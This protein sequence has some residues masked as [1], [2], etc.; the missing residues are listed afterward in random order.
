MANLKPLA[1]IEL[2]DLID[3][4]RQSIVDEI[5]SRM[6]NDPKWS[7][8]TNG[9][10]LHH[11]STNAFL[12]IASY[13]AEKITSSQNRIT[14]DL[15]L[16][17]AIDK[18]AI[19]DL[20]FD[21]KIRPRQNKHAEVKVRGVVQDVI[22]DKTFYL[23][24]FTPLTATNLNGNATTY[25]IIKYDYEEG[26]FNYFDD[27]KIDPSVYVRDFFD[28][29]AYSGSTFS[30]QFEITNVFE[31]FILELENITDIIENS[32]RVYYH[33]KNDYI[34]L[35]ET[36]TFVVAPKPENKYFPNGKPHYILQYGING[37][38]KIYFGTEEFGG[39]FNSSHT[40]GEIVVFGRTGG[41]ENSRITSNSI[42]DSITLP[43]Y[44]NRELTIGFFN[45]EQGYGGSDRES[46]LELKQY[47]PMRAGKGEAIISEEDMYEAL[48][49]LVN[50]HKISSPHYDEYTQTVQILHA[51]HWIVPKRS[52][53][54]MTLPISSI[55][56]SPEEYTL[57][58]TEYLNDF[59]NIK[60]ANDT[61]ITD[62]IATSTFGFGSDYFS[63]SFARPLQVGHPM[64][65][66]LQINAY[67]NEEELIDQLKFDGVYKGEINR[68]A[69]NKNHA[70]VIS[71]SFSSFT[72][73]NN[74]EITLSFDLYDDL[75]ITISIPSGTYTPIGIS[76]FLHNEIF[77]NLINQNLFTNHQNHIYCYVDPGNN[78]RIIIE[79]P[80]TGYQ[81]R[82]KILSDPNDPQNLN[83][84]I[85]MDKKT[86]FAYPRSGLVFN[87][88]TLYNHNDYVIFYSINN[89]D[90]N[91]GIN[92]QNEIDEDKMSVID[93][94][95]LWE[96]NTFSSQGPE[97]NHIL[98]DEK[99]DRTRLIQGS[100]LIVGAYNNNGVLIDQ[101]TFGSVQKNNI[102]E[103]IKENSQYDV[104]K[105]NG[106]TF[107]YDSSNLNL[108]IVDGI[109]IPIYK[110][111]HPPLAAIVIVDP[112][113]YNNVDILKGIS[114]G[115]L[116]SYTN[117]KLWEHPNRYEI[118]GAHIE[119][120]TSV[121]TF[122]EN[123]N[124]EIHLKDTSATPRTL[125]KLNFTYNSTDGITSLTTS[126]P[127]TPPV[128][129]IDTS[130]D[131]N[132][133]YTENKLSFY[134]LP[135]EVDT[136]A[137]KEY[138]S[139]IVDDQDNEINIASIK[140]GYNKQIYDFITVDYKPNHYQ[141]FDEG[142]YFINLLKG[143]KN[144]RMLGWEHLIK[145]IDFR[146][147]GV[148]VTITAKRG[149]SL[150]TIEKNTKNLILDNFGYDNNNP[151]HNIGSGFS[152]SLLKSIISNQELNPGV[153]NVKVNFPSD[154]IVDTTENKT[155]YYFIANEELINKI[156]EVEN[157][158]PLVL[159][160]LTSKYEISVSVNQE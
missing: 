52:F 67:N 148:S 38:V 132:I 146:I 140:L 135:G 131:H 6:Q 18:T 107:N 91:Q 157:A 110:A 151:N 45:P 96:Q 125:E 82:V 147:V 53:E 154:D 44:A 121:I 56:T 59:C 116:A 153:A 74:L 3:F 111:S 79:S 37:E 33:Y 50:K 7:E 76:E 102:T 32:V 22:L 150:S 34:E 98:L 103:A 95:G 137:T 31:K 97:F 115:V 99:K 129:I 130:K 100:N 14:R 30:K 51:L 101:L 106:N 5:I 70:Q 138:S 39:A 104:F 71:D 24:R 12:Q 143:K 128:S 26:K 139:G 81:S 127:L 72:I 93:N 8:L 54:D 9:I 145:T 60:G 64:H 149:V 152:I 113:T 21:Q 144:K 42:S 10:D 66:T 89:N 13:I 85:G 155:A 63:L 90:I 23:P 16:P 19:E 159:K 142:K 77:L 46:L 80:T 25:E 88:N 108:K 58:L 156:Q 1:E 114:N 69:P 120:D 84:V 73:S 36:D 123:N 28:V 119:I 48:R 41:G 35:P 49:K 61:I 65:T 86:Y 2:P 158:D 136:E 4:D 17:H 109:E 62:E 27:I 47:G 78:G 43:Y 160:G 118:N 124:Y 117:P 105:P 68:P 122:T 40:D 112:T 92:E 57:I 134:F 20:I 11:N 75:P 55:I 83:N 87:N 126:S 133:I 15:Y 141:P 29:Y 94:T